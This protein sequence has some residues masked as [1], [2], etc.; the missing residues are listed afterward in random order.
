MKYLSKYDYKL[1]I[2][3]LAIVFV[4]FMQFSF[5]HF[6]LDSYAVRNLDAKEHAS[7]YFASGRITMSLFIL[8]TDFLNID[9]IAMMRISYIIAILS[10]TTSIYLINQHLIKRQI[11]RYTSLMIAFTLI[12]SP[13]VIELFFFPEYTGMSTFSIYAATASSLKLHEYFETKQQKTLYIS[14]GLFILAA[15]SYQSSAAYFIILF[16]LWQYTSKFK[17][18]RYL[19]AFSVYAIGVGVSLIFVKLANS[20]R[21]ASASANVSK[22]DRLQEMFQEITKIVNSGIFVFDPLFY[23]VSL[24]ALFVIAIM[25]ILKNK[26][27]GRMFNF[28]LLIGFTTVLSLAPHLVTT[29]FEMPPR[30]ILGFGM[31]HAVLFA[32]IIFENQHALLIKIA[33][34][35]IIVL[36]IFQMYYWQRITTTHFQVNIM[37]RYEVQAITQAIHKYEKSSGNTVRYVIFLDDHKMRKTYRDINRFGGGNIRIGFVD[38]ALIPAIENEL[39]RKLFLGISSIDKDMQ[40]EKEQYCL[41]NDW[42]WFDD[43]QLS[44]ENNTVFICRY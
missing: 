13:F 11:A 44:F 7:I 3:I 36:S 41:N 24:L 31:L 9:F 14:T 12:L 33:T 30:T 39:H 8:I 10:L 43:M 17:L 40:D 15:C 22:I 19:I 23:K 25:S 6:G 26:V 38:W 4:I 2:L 1:Y 42:D 21:I 16:S 34:L 20:T 5:V 18:S 32:I 27:K 37:D 35:I 28:I 29:G